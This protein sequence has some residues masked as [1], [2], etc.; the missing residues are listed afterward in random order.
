MRAG[1]WIGR[2]AAALALLLMVNVQCFGQTH[3]ANKGGTAG[4]A[5]PPKPTPKFLVATCTVSGTSTSAGAQT[6]LLRFQCQPVDTAGLVNGNPA[7]LSLQL[8]CKPPVPVGPEPLCV[9][10]VPKLNTPFYVS[11]SAAGGSA[12]AQKLIWGDA[13]QNLAVKSYTPISAA[14][15]VIR[16]TKPAAG[17]AT[18]GTVDLIVQVTDESTAPPDPCTLFETPKPKQPAQVNMATIVS[19][20]G[21][22]VPF[23]LAAQGSNSVLIYATTAR[24]PAVA[25][26]NLEDSIRD[27][28]ERSISTLE[29]TPPAGQPFAVELEIPH[30]SAMGDLATR[31]NSLNYSQFKIQDVGRTKISVTATS[32]PDC[33]TWTRFLT[34]IR[35][36]SWD[37]VSVPLNKKL[38]YLSSS[39]VATAFSGL[40]TPTASASGG[41]G[42]AGGASGGAGAGASAG[43]TG[44][45]TGAGGASGSGSGAVS[46]GSGGG[47]AGGSGGASG[48]GAG[49]NGSTTSG[50]SGQSSSSANATI[51]ITQPPGSN[52]VINSDV[53][54]CVT[55]AGSS[56][57]C[58]GSSSSSASGS[59]GAASGG[60]ASASS[61]PTT[62]P[63]QGPISMASVAV[64][65]GTVEQFPPD[66]LVYAD[67]IPGDDALVKERNRVIAQLDLPRPEMILTAWVTQ[68]SSRSPE[69][70]GAFNNMI[71]NI[72]A[73]YD[74]QFGEV[75][76]RGW[77]SVKDQMLDCRYFDEAFRSYIED[78]FI[79]DGGMAAAGGTTTQALSQSFLDSSQANPHWPLQR[80]D[81]GICGPNRYCLGYNQLFH[82]LKPALTDLILTIVAAKNPPDVAQK[83]VTAVQGDAPPAL[84]ES[85]CDGLEDVQR[86]RCRAIWE[87]MEAGTQSRLSTFP[88]CAR[89]DFEGIMGSFLLSNDA[90][91]HLECFLDQAELLDPNK[92]RPTLIGLTRA[93]IANFLFNYKI[94]QQY[95]HEFE[96]FDLSNSADALNNALSPLIDSFNRDLWTYQLF[97]RADMQ[98]R[99]EQLN[100]DTDGRCCVKKVFGLDKPSFFNDGLVTVRTISGQSTTVNTTSQSY[101]NASSAP[102]LSA[103]LNSLAG[104]AGGGAGGGGGGGGSTGTS[105]TTTTTTTTTSAGGGA[106]PSPSTPKP[107]GNYAQIAGAL[108]NYQ[109]TYA[110]IGRQLN[111]TATPRSLNTASS[112]EITVTLNADESASGPLYTG[113][114]SSDPATNTSRVA[115]HDTTTRVRVDS[116]K[117]FEIS[118]FSA[119][120]E[121]SHSRFPLLPPFVEIPYIGTL[122]G[123]PLGSAKEFHTS[124]AIISAYVIPTATDIANGLPEAQDLIVDGLN[125]GDCSVIVEYRRPTAD[126]ACVFRPMLSLR[127]AGQVTISQFNKTFVGCLA[128][129]SLKI[130]AIPCSNLTFR[131][132]LHVLSN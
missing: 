44:G 30:A 83:A 34:D 74:L 89:R 52:I 131:D 53:T 19:L 15:V 14:P 65:A 109:T 67:P 94:S 119:I 63:A 124:S 98:Y 84:F 2:W 28:A 78:E 126:K 51:E 22:A 110:Q 97:I 128:N 69:T 20:L 101:L 70:V 103:I 3:A 87:N 85:Q 80:P 38:F 96:P 10:P 50:A 33:A 121:R 122:A 24:P 75:V 54:P 113:G 23:T 58:P 37:L 95:P 105:G 107:V 125:A 7:G 56:N 17:D 42:A 102:Q 81:L 47:A 127:D 4:G 41:A 68:D 118:S 39:D 114:G 130:N 115:S 82:P 62:P 64:V 66:L 116:I 99:V 35:E 129:E 104:L 29:V 108:A 57:S 79:T 5:A 60:N 120:V 92:T 40:S 73:D 112:A 132:A 49:S 13:V 123:I 46:G 25:L 106:A 18:V 71:K 90:R 31:F 26:K 86:K 21:N 48:G 88:D 117:L 61:T 111:F 36:A 6:T 55:T 12:P 45:A 59:S 76:R 32:A 72:V 8:A 16:V 93:A 9:P 43:G 27:M 1:M 11:E 77:E 100:S 91:V